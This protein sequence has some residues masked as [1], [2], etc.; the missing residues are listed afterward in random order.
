MKTL[1][2]PLA[3]AAAALPAADPALPEFNSKTLELP[4][5]T[6]KEI[7]NEPKPVQPPQVRMAEP[8][9][10]LPSAPPRVT[11]D[12]GMPILRPD[13]KI[14]Y[15]MIVKAPDPAIDYK[16]IVRPRETAK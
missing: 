12:S 8:R 15:K 4:S 16:M 1:L 9:P 2:L 7:L 6:L 10:T 13:A 11:R 5:L 14:D 3:F